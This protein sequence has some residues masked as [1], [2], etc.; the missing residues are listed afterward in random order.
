M[1]FGYLVTVNVERTEGKFAERSEIGD[2][3]ESW[4]TDANQGTVSGM[5]ADA[6][7]EY[8]VSDWE[9]EEY[10]PDEVARLRKANRDML[11]LLDLARCS[12]ADPGIVRSW[13]AKRSGILRRK[14]T[15]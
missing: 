12:S 10:D 15:T 3:L 8:E 2:E 6:M 9:V 14:G 4:V 1:R 5:G 13:A 7:S 11:D